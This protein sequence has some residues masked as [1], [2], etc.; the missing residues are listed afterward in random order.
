[1]SPTRQSVIFDWNGTLLA[2][3]AL[4]LRTTNQTL[5]LFGVKPVTMARYRQEYTMP[6]NQMYIAFGCDPQEIQER[7]AELVAAWGAYYNEHKN[8]LRLRRGAKETVHHIKER[9]HKVAILSNYTTP[10]IISKA[11]RHDMA[12]HFDAVLANHPDEAANVML[13]RSKGERLK[14]FVETHE[15]QKALLVGDTPEEIEIAHAY[16]YL[17]V[18]LTDGVCSTARLGAAKPDFMIRSLTEMPEIV[19]SVFGKGGAT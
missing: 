8:S 3:T 17:G 5:A 13:K 12:H 11:M 19:E 1:M 4:C 7:N 6:L 14:A 18:A 10:D 9:G 16:G 2:D 15:I